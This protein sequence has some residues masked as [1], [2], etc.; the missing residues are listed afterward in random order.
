[1]YEY[2]KFPLLATAPSFLDAGP[3]LG[4]AHWNMY[5][6]ST[7]ALMVLSFFFSSPLVAQQT[8]PADKRFTEEQLKLFLVTEKD[9][10][11]ESNKIMQEAA[12]S[13][14]DPANLAA[15]KI[16]QL[17]QACL[18]RHGI[19]R[20]DFESVGE[21]A[22]EAFDAVAYLDGSYKNSLDHF[23]AD[24]APQ[25]AA[26]AEAQKQLAIYQEAEKNGWRVLSSEDRDAAIKSASAEQQAA[27]DE[28]KQRVEDVSTNETEAVQHDADADATGR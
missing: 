14:T 12:S 11:D 8:R 15:G 1:M 4:F 22:A 13:K 19:S 21:R 2:R 7:A 10:I 27:M 28:V 5:L 6:R 18:D 17:Y 23:E 3:D 25:N 24:S 26:L 9:W 20:E 16:G